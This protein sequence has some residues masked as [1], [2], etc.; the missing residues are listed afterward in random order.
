MTKTPIGNAGAV[1]LTPAWRCGDLVIT[2]GQVPVDEAG[3][4]VAGTIEE[5]THAVMR[6]IE[7]VL[8][9]AGCTLD[10]VVKTTVWLEDARDFA[11]FNAVYGSYFQ[12]P[13]PAR[14]TVEARLMIDA[15][16]EIEAMAYKPEAA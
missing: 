7:A 12:G 11:R 16:I 6:R 3:K 14:S 9:D 15:K 1:P 4:L 8:K 10:D 2:S 5:Q 13:P